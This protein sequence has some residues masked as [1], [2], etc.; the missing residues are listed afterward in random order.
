MEGEER[1]PDGPREWREEEKRGR[2]R[3]GLVAGEVEEE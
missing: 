2:R 1:L 3:D